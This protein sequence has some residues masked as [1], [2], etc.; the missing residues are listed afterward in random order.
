VVNEGVS[1]SR[2]TGGLNIMPTIVARHFAAKY[3]LVQYGTNDS[4]EGVNTPS[5]KG[6]VPGNPG[7]AGSF[8][9]Y[10]QRIIDIIQGNG[11][12][13]ILAKVPI[14][15][16]PCGSCTPYPDPDNAPRNALIRDYNV[17]IGELVSANGISVTPPDF[18]N[19]FRAHLYDEMS[20]NYHPNGV[21]YQSMANMWS[22][23]LTQ[24]Q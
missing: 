4:A 13:P 9:D 5:G 17:V 23:A 6:L 1:G 11:K 16:G 3:F 22:A 20:D 12:H 2:A 8:K 14:A 7:Y 19:H 15:R 10:M 21:G 18:Y 24:S